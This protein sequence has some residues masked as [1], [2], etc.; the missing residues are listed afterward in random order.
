MNQ[1]GYWLHLSN[2]DAGAWR[3][4]FARESLQSKASTSGP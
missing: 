3:A 2:V 1:Q 4:T